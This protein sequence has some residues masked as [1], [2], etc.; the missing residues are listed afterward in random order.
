MENTI[1]TQAL[2][3]RNDIAAPQS[4]NAIRALT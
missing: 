2:R 3:M 4:R 1:G